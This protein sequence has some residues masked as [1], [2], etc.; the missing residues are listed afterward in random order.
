MQLFVNDANILIDLLSIELLSEFCKLPIQLSTSDFVFEELYGNQKAAIEK[1]EKLTIIKTETT[2]D[3]LGINEIVVNSTGLSFEDC[4]VW[5][6]SKKLGGTLLSGD[7]KLRKQATQGDI[8]VRGI[9][10]ILDELVQE[11][12]IT[13]STAFQKLTVLKSLNPRLPKKEIEKRLARWSI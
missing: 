11:E 1:L 6:Y 7:G 4:S 5:F 13:K 8:Q 3:Y 10:F 9:L 12:I 2:E